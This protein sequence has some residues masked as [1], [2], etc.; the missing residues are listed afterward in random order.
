MIKLPKIKTS[1]NSEDMEACLSK[2]RE[3][4]VNPTKTSFVVD[5]KKSYAIDKMIKLS[6]PLDLN[7]ASIN[8]ESLVIKREDMIEIH[9]FIT[10][11]SKDIKPVLVLSGQEGTGRTTL[12]RAIAF[13]SDMTLEDD[14]SKL[15]ENSI[16]VCK[17][18]EDFLQNEEILKTNPIIVVR[19]F[20]VVRTLFGEQVIEEDGFTDYKKFYFSIK[21]NSSY[22][23][24]KD[25]FSELVKKLLSHWSLPQDT[26]SPKKVISARL[27][28][29]P[30]SLAL[31]FSRL[32]NKC[33]I[34]GFENAKEYF[35]DYFDSKNNSSS[36]RNHNSFVEVIQPKK[37]LDDFFLCENVMRKI[38]FFIQR[39]SSTATEYEFCS[40]LRKNKRTV[41]LFSGPPG[42]GKSMAAEVIANSLG[43]ELWIIDFSQ[44][45]SMFMGQTEKGLTKIFKEAEISDAILLIDE[46]DTLLRSRK[47]AFNEHTIKV[48][49]HMLNLLEA[50]EGNIILTTNSPDS[51]DNAF[52]RRI[53]VKVTFEIPTTEISVQILKSLLEP[54]APVS[55]CLDLKTALQGIKLSGGLLRNAVENLAYKLSNGEIAAIN[56]EILRKALLEIQEEE[57]I[58]N[59]NTR[60]VGIV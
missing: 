6:N 57:S 51:L 37:H 33:E 56:T 34:Y 5:L 29:T 58:L 53:D 23:H 8:L 59:K 28:L 17:S 54:D 52:S 45:Q 1:D 40:K 24:E 10:S 39:A 49:N 20:E 9:A 48:S 44:I 3:L 18:Y 30:G 36:K 25:L 27:E 22:Y 26:I 60:K 43:K 11:I 4:M 2:Y 13:E 50:H 15:D 42:T 19:E 12:A 38:Q 16:L 21:F 46:C 35:E 32:H 47:E 7:K 31:H 41:G 55:D 14:P